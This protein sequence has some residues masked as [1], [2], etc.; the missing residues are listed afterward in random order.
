MKKKGILLIN[1]GTPDSPGPADVKKYLLEFLMD[2]RVIDYGWLK[3]NLLV[4]GIIIPAR[5][6]NSAKIYKEIWD[7]VTGSPLLYHSENLTKK[8]REALPEEYMVE[9]A[10]RYQ[11]PSIES[12]LEKLRAAAVDEIIILPLYPQYASSST[13]TTYEKVMEITKKW[14]AMPAIRWIGCFYDHPKFIQ[15]FVNNIRRHRPEEYDHIVFSYHGLP[16]R[17]MRKADLSGKH[18]VADN[19]TCC[20]TI[21]DANRLCYRAQCKASTDLMVEQLGLTKEQYTMS[22]QSRLGR[23]PWIQ[24]FTDHIL[25]ELAQQG[26]K[27][28][29]IVCPAFVAD[30]LETL[31]EISFEYQEE[32]QN[33][34]GEKVQLVESLNSNDDWVDAVVDMVKA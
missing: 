1:L 6:K 10:M 17:H 25:K 28:I 27:K 9:L 15:S 33:A 34:G 3:R 21:C 22:F 11:S 19:Y 16:E 30:C 2:E 23:D 8:V 14:N 18:C 20:A 12:G 13:G 4:K 31:Y 5:Y 24:P 29:L 7:D 26:K 32:F